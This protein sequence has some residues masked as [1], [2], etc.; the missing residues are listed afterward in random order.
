[1]KGSRESSGKT[2]VGR[3]DG[4]EEVLNSGRELFSIGSGG[5]MSSVDGAHSQNMRGG[6]EV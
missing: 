1:M 3:V 2:G 4:V 5:V 6:C